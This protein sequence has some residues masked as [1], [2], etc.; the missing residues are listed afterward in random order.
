MHVFSTQAKMHMLSYTTT[1][2]DQN[3][4]KQEKV[5]T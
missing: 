3:T 4:A 5:K 2:K 1:M